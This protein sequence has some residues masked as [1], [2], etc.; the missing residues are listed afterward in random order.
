MISSKKYLAEALNPNDIT[1]IT[2]T[3]ITIT[4]SRA[5]AISASC[6]YLSTGRNKLREEAEEF[7][8]TARNRQGYN[9]AK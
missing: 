8:S 9:K 6:S 1:R 2:K 7:V 3:G 4:D 5:M